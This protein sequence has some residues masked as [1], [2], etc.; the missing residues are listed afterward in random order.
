MSEIRNDRK[1][2]KEHEWAIVEGGELKV[3]ITDYAQ[4]SL[5]DI[6]FVEVKGSGSEVNAGDTFGT[7]ESV[8][9]AEDLYMPVKGTISSTNEDLFATPEKINS[10]PY[11]SWLVSIKDFDQSAFDSLM[12]S[13][14]YEDYVKSL[15]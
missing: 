2:T 10:E 7:I 3:G 9:A 1:Y 14:S 12:D 13:A 11:D 8:K 6:V 5:G 15:E 4:N